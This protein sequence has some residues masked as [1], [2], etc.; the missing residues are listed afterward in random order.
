M[1]TI[2]KKDTSDNTEQN[3]KDFETLVFPL[4]DRLYTTALT[5]T[6]DTFDAEDLVQ[7]TYLKA[8][9]YYPRFEP[10]TNIH[11][12]MYRILTNSFINNYNT[13]K[14]MPHREDFETICTFVPDEEAN[15][16]D[17]MPDQNYLENY[18]EIFD[19]SI[20]SALDK[21]PQNYRIVVLLSDVSELKYKEI[22]ELLDCPLGT[23]MSRINRGRKLLAQFLKK[24]AV[25]NGF[26]NN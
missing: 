25:K 6:K 17:E 26:A 1:N 20:T 10:G 3:R 24:Y 21:L 2:F 11:G 14:R 15:E 9:Y 8:W 12:W 7:T 16:T 19:D 4:M 5:M 18:H 22:A 13:K 23:V